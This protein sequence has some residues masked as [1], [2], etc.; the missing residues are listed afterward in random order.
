MPFEINRIVAKEDLLIRPRVSY[1]ISES[2][3]D[4]ID[5]EILKP[6]KV[7]QSEKYLYEFTL[8][9]SFQIPTRQIN[10]GSPYIT[11]TRKYSTHK[12]FTTFEKTTKKAFLSVNASDIDQNIL[13]DDYA[14]IVYIMFADYLL[15]NYK[16]LKKQTFDN[17]IDK[18]D[19]KKINSYKHPAPFEEQK[20]ILDEGGDVND[21]DDY[22][23]KRTDKWIYIKTEY[24]KHY[25]F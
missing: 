1:R 8:S 14:R 12:G 2:V 21:W 9:F 22:V 24:L 19:F 6:N 23:N 16:K 10:Y 18:L 20:Y 7:L 17:L 5:Q 25:K 4:F 15:R 13:P 11:E 3:F